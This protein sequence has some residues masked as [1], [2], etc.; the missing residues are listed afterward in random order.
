MSGGFAPCLKKKKK[1]EARKG[2]YDEADFSVRIRPAR[3]LTGTI[4]VWPVWPK[5]NLP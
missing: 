3:Y 5:P 2:T 1:K 4:V